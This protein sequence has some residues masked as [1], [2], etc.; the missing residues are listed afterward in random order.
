MTVACTMDHVLDVR[1]PDG[2]DAAD[3]GVEV[4]THVSED[5]ADVVY[6]LKGTKGLTLRL[7]K[8]VA[9]HS[10]RHV[11][12]EELAF[13]CARTVNRAKDVGFSTLV[14]D[15]AEWLAEFWERSDVQVTGQPAI[16]QAVRWNIFQ[17]AQASA[18]AET[19]GVPAKGVTGSGYGGHYFWDT[20]V[21]VMPFLSY[22]NPSTP[23]TP[24][25]SATRCSRPR[26]TGR[27]NCRTTACCSRGGRSTGGSPARTT[28]PGRRSTTST[29]TSRTRS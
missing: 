18:R 10:S 12:A 27:G 9:Y 2:G 29:R 17:L 1:T 20:E 26:G 25:G 21:Y 16:Q 3:V 15:Q 11:S 28:R 22:T 14:D 24:C 19:Q 4:S 5:V 23:G 13:R 6:H 7:E 8:F